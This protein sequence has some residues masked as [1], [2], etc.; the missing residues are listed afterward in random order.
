[1]FLKQIGWARFFYCVIYWFP[2]FRWNELKCK[3]SVICS[4]FWSAKIFFWSKPRIIGVRRVS[5][6][7]VCRKC[8][9]HITWLYICIYV[10]VYMYMYICIYVYMYIC[11]YVYMYI[12]IYVYVYMYICICICICIYMNMYVHSNFKRAILAPK[13]GPKFWPWDG[14]ILMRPFWP[15]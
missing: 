8:I 14:P 15:H 11:I 13:M 4:Y 3:F 5:W 1:V 6:R 2:Y 10:Y 7:Y 12:C 9:R